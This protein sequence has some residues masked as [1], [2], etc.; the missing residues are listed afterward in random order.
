[1]AW[2]Q[3]DLGQSYRINNVNIYH[4]KEDGENKKFFGPYENKRVQFP[5]VQGP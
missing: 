5:G 1:M 4:R 2:L 3:M